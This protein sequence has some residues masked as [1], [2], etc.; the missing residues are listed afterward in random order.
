MDDNRN[1][2]SDQHSRFPIRGGL[3]PPASRGAPR[4]VSRI[5]TMRG[6]LAGPS[7]R[8]SERYRADYGWNQSLNVR[9][10]A[11]RAQRPGELALDTFEGKPPWQ[12]PHVF[13]KAPWWHHRL[14][15]D[16]AECVRFAS[17]QLLPGDLPLSAIGKREWRMYAAVPLDSPRLEWERH[18]TRSQIQ[19]LTMAN[20]IK[21]P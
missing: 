20:H 16:E 21:P 17:D 12:Y 11:R 1:R 15:C 4:R 8:F 3:R 10:E 18:R 19:E 13:A 5:P 7:G 9:A 2:P 6:S 14:V